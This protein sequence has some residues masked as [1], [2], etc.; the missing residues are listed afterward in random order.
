MLKSI[1]TFVFLFVGLTAAHAA[2]L[3]NERYRLTLLGQKVLVAVKGTP[4][5]ELIPEFTVLYSERNPGLDR[6][7]TNY[8]LSH[9]YSVLWS[10]CAVDLALMNEWVNSPDMKAVHR[11]DRVDIVED[12][13][14]QRT[15]FYKD[16]DGKVRARVGGRYAQGISNPFMA[17][18]QYRVTATRAVLTND[19]IVWSFDE[20]DGFALTAQLTL[21]RPDGDPQIRY[22]LTAR[23]PGWYSAAFTGAPTIKVDDSLPVPQQAAG[24]GLRQFNHLISEAYLKLPRAH[25]ASPGLNIAVVVDPAQ[26]PFRIVSDGLVAFTIDNEPSQSR[27]GLS[28]RRENGRLQPVAFAPI[29][30]GFGSKMKA[31]DSHDFQIHYV[32]KGGDWKETYRHIARR[33]YRFRDLRDNSGSGSLNSTIENLVDYCIDRDGHNYAMWHA[34]QKYYNYWSDKSG[35]FKPFSPLFGLTAAIVTDDEE[36]YRKRALPAVEFAVSRMNNVFSPYDVYDN[37][38]ISQTDRRLGASYVSAIQL[39]SLYHLFQGRTE[40]FRQFAE[41]KGFSMGPLQR[42]ARQSLSNESGLS[43]LAEAI[44]AARASGDYMNCL[45]VY[46]ATKQ[47][48][49]LEAAVEGAYH[50]ASLLNLF[51]MVPDRDVTLEKG[52]KVPVHAHSYGR[53]RVWGFAPPEPISRPQQTVPAWRASLIGLESPAYPGEYWMNHHGILMRIAA[54]AGDSMLAELSRWGMVGRFGNYPGDNRS[55]DSLIAEFPDTPLRYIYEANFSTFNP[56][57]A[58]DFLGA[59]IDFLLADAFYR[60]DKQ[61]DFPA[62]SME[63]AGFRSRAYGDRPGV[64]YGEKNVTLWLPRKLVSASSRQVDY[65]AGYGNGKFYIAFWNQSAHEEDVTVTLNPALVDCRLP[66]TA[67]VW[68]DNREA[69]EVR[70]ADNRLQFRVGSRG[71][72]AYAVEGVTVRR[73]LHEKMFSPAATKLGSDSMRRMAAPFGQIH[74]MLIRMGKDLT[75]AF[76]YTDALPEDVI[77]ATFRYRQGRGEWKEVVDEIFPYELSTP[78]DDAA[79]DFECLLEIENADQQVQR[80]NI[81]KLKL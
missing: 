14:G 16:R 7:H 66:H 79:G 18:Q 53:H 32:Q 71:I 57:H 26:S 33:I 25:L 28:I 13:A 8:Y 59:V 3:Q 43:A 46:E 81:I 31:G 42:L 20:Q 39:A 35:V 45:E 23:K 67:R 49:W 63:G 73:G 15:W 75:S 29:L 6:N 55:N 44:S 56:G 64:F 76:V 72:V 77:S 51:P 4:D 37:G 30:G 27:Y 40:A 17:G 54:Y 80:S 11:F 22:T 74:A 5:Q 24:R 62:R 41:E 12:A 19:S 47:P 34:E 52:N 60:S 69:G 1:S 50:E 21:P 38:M 65:V 10:R 9:R 2:D 78:L 61:I 58:W 36:F 68:R 48:R 70:V